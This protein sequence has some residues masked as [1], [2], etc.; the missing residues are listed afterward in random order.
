MLRL[1]LP[2]GL[3]VPVD[4][5]ALKQKKVFLYFYFIQLTQHLIKL[6]TLECEWLIISTLVGLNVYG[7][8]TP[9]SECFWYGHT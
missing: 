4:K 2:P 6:F 1:H 9:E 7:M 5:N 3:Q 8:D